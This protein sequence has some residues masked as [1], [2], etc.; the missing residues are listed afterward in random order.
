[1]RN[2]LNPV[3]YLNLNIKPVVTRSPALSHKH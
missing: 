3:K 2:L 1:M